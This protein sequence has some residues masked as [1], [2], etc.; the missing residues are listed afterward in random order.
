MML[1]LPR[2]VICRPILP[3]SQMQKLAA[4]FLR[5]AWYF[6]RL[7]VDVIVIL[8]SMTRYSMTAETGFWSFVTQDTTAWLARLTISSISAASRVK[9][10]ICR[11]VCQ[12]GGWVTLLKVVPSLASLNLNSPT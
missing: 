2:K 8:P 10:E 1:T 12:A 3:G 9:D 4:G 7:V 5:Q 6:A 11:R